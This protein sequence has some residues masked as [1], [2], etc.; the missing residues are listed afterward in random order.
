LCF[1]NSQKPKLG[2]VVSDEPLQSVLRVKCE[3]RAAAAYGKQVPFGSQP[4]GA[5]VTVYA[6]SFGTP[7]AGQQGASQPLE[8]CA[9]VNARPPDADLLLLLL[10]CRRCCWVQ[11]V[12]L[13][14]KVSAGL[15]SMVSS[16]V[17]DLESLKKVR[18]DLLCCKSSLSCC[19]VSQTPAGSDL[20][21]HRKVCAGLTSM[22]S[23]AVYDLES[24]KNVCIDSVAVHSA[25]QHP[26]I[27]NCW[28]FQGMT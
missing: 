4:L 2:W 14:N 11:V 6:L 7:R 22:V 25:S 1:V 12:D 8:C 21:V 15:T 18:N 13:P 27:W 26:C 23:S 10:C 20:Y 19:S 16:A 28:V 5:H 9:C 17:Y 3:H 24:L